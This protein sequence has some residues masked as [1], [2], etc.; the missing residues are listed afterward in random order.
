MC[1]SV[2]DKHKIIG[3]RLNR[4]QGKNPTK[5]IGITT[6][7][8]KCI[9]CGLIYSNP[10]PIPFDI[11]D[12]YG[13]PP[14]SYWKEN[15]FK[16]NENYFKN[17]IEIL[18][19]LLH[20]E[21]GMKS[22]DIGAGL[23]HQMKALSNT[24]FET[25]GLEPSKQFYERAI[26]KM[27][28][29]SDRMRLGMIDLVEYPENHFDFISFSAVLEHLYNPSSSILKAIKWVKP[30]GIIHIEVPS[31]DHLIGKVI[32]LFYKLN[33]TDY[34][35]N[36]SPMHAPFHLYEFTL[37]SFQQHSKKYG[38]ELAFH[39]HYVCQTYMPKIADYFLVPYMKWTNTGMQLCVWLRKK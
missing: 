10:Q 9:D 34:V 32:N 19:K 16:F 24:G 21:H 2:S 4:H 7:V 38:Y 28:I 22:L 33:R 3:K 30:N 27:G 29:N 12:H 36:L 25:Y 31:A 14:E 11:Q 13:V 23:G 1:G 15:Y 20:F 17:E 39:E 37:K 6:T 26:L 18:K 8:V 5:K 35:T